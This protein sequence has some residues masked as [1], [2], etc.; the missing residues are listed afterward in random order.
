MTR[1]AS[2]I[3]AIVALGGGCADGPQSPRVDLVLV[4]GHVIDVE[5]GETLRDR[6]VWI[7]EGRI[8]SIA[9][10]GA[11]A[12]PSGT[13]TVDAHDH[14][15]A[16]GL[17]GAHVHLDHI[18]ELELYTAKGVTTVFNMRGLPQHLNWRD[19][20]ARGERDGPTIYTAGDYMDGYPPFM[21]PMMSFDNPEE[22]AA[23]VR[24]QRDAGYDMIKVYTRLSLEQLKAIATAAR[25]VG[26]PV[27]GHGSA[28]YSLAE[29][30][31]SGQVNAAH[32]QD[33]LRWYIEDAEDEAGVGE[34]V[35]TLRGTA[36]TVTANLSFTAGLIRQAEDLD[37]LLAEPIARSLPAAILQ[38]FRRANNRYVRRGIDWLPEV[39]ARFEMEKRLARELH[40]AG[41]TLLAG[42]DASTAGVLPGT[43]LHHEIELLVEAGLSPVDALRAATLAPG[44]F[45][46]EHIDADARF[47]QVVEGYRAD[48][49]VVRGNP[50][51][52]V[53]RLADAAGVVVRGRWLDRETLDARLAALA[54]KSRA[55]TPGVIEIENAIKSGDLAAAREPFDAVRA[56]TPNEILFSQYVPFFIGYGYLYGDDGFNPDPARRAAALTLYQMYAETYPAFHSAHYMLALA[57]EANDD[58]TAAIASLKDALAIHPYYPDARQKL[59]ELAAAEAAEDGH[60]D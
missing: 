18:D 44:R 38:P 8:V 58:A 35:E 32:G 41:V 37:G 36:M 23:S 39:K 3:L 7:A 25:E 46:A 4:G 33:L 59:A 5:S 1:T 26:L 20:I 31:D 29:L 10:S 51:E 16:P 28:N 54:E 53:A 22:A 40:G 13:M 9:P 55:V 21:Q 2:A 45:V 56:E 12:I 27:V 15:L 24:A 47:G 48:I 34:I 17:V 30:V 6:D 42:T 43:A 19:A 14:F 50:L 57:H 49:L 60:S 52:D 11:R